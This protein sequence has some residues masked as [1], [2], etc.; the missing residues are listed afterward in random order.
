MRKDKIE[1]PEEFVKRIQQVDYQ[2]N[3]RSLNETIYTEESGDTEIGDLQM[4]DYD[5]DAEI[6]NHLDI[7]CFLKSLAPRERVVIEKHIMQ[8]RTLDSIGKDY[9]LTRE[10]IRQIVAK[11]IRKMKKFAEKNKYKKEDWL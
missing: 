4:S 7:S 1:T 11:G 3:V 6:M 5:I 2:T 8:G 10:R 9:G